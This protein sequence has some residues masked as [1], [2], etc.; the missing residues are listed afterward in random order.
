[1]R[2][3]LSF[4]LIL[5]LVSYTENRQV[6]AILNHAET[7]MSNA[8]D[9]A[10]ALVRGIDG[11]S[12]PTKK[13]R[14][15]H[16]LLLSMAQDK[17]YFDVTKDSTILVAYAYFR[18]H[19]NKHDHLL[20][21]YYMGVIRE[22]AKEYINAALAFREAEPLAEE[23]K[24][25]RQLSLIEQHLSHIYALNYDHVRS[26]EYAEKSVSAAEQ[27]GESIM[28]DYCRYDV[29]VQ[30]LSEYRYEDAKSILKQILD[31][32]DANTELFSFAAKKMAHVLLY[33]KNPDTIKAKEYY[34]E[35]TKNKTSSLSSHDFGVLALISEKENEP[36][37]ADSYLDLSER[38][39]R[40]PLDSVMYFNDCRNVYDERKDWEKAHQ[41]KTTSARI[42]DRMTIELLG[43]SLTHAMEIYYKSTWEIEKERSRSRLLLFILIGTLLVIASLTLFFILR[44]RNQRTL[45]EMAFIQ[46]LSSDLVDTLV[47]DKVKSL[48]QLSESYFSWEDEAVVK[49]ES[50]MGKLSKDEIITSFRTQ[51]GKLRNDHSIIATLERSLD[52]TD[53]GIMEKARHYLR[54]EKELAFSILTLLFSGFTIRS[55]SF[56]LRMSEASLRMRKTRFKQQFQSLPDPV[57][58]LF[59]KKLG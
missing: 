53:N 1:M 39:L 47:I 27:A 55:I 15:R 22:N 54:N 49:R 17:C 24:D 8:P 43:Q 2:Q 48:K 10:L 7:C 52:L 34:L 3:L 56:L 21:S 23:L 50:K 30:L 33:G 28:A 45:E 14:A 44:K 32:N 4:V 46:E 31:A 59:I 57:R 37:K 58:S 19:G 5:C 41:A 6:R 26:L 13:L 20:A 35:I 25:Y 51:L 36:G 42:Q 38:L 40:S 29:A 11:Q 9:S 18:Y 16:A 12:L